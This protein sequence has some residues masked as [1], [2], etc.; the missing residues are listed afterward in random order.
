MDE[1]QYLQDVYPTEWACGGAGRFGFAPEA[2][3]TEASPLLTPVN[4]ARLHQEL[5]TY[6]D[7]D[8]TIAWKRHLEISLRRAFFRPLFPTPTSS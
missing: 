1:G 3:L 5:E 2:H 6:W 8:K 4:V 7:R